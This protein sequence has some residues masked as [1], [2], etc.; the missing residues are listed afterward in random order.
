[1]SFNGPAR[2]LELLG[3]LGVVTPLQQQFDDLLFPWAQPHSLILHQIPL[4]FAS[5]SGLPWRT[6]T[7]YF[8]KS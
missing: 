5:P 4:C 6:V 2:H 3:N 1:M 7:G 8:Q